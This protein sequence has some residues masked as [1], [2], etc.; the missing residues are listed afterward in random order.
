VDQ[1][2][3]TVSLKRCNEGSYYEIVAQGVPDHDLDKTKCTMDRVGKVLLQ[4]KELAQ[5][6]G[7]DSEEL[8][9]E[10]CSNPIIP[11]RFSTDGS[12]SP[13]LAE[14]IRNLAARYVSQP[15]IL[16]KPLISLFEAGELADAWLGM[17]HFCDV[18]REIVRQEVGWIFQQKGSQLT[19]MDFSRVFHRICDAM[20]IPP[21]T[22]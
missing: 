3:V 2:G 19:A 17:E 15:G 16:N 8:A 13:E 21:T 1:W 4:A 14:A 9:K 5:K 18:I 7:T 11:I 20:G 10:L 22:D 6:R 12:A